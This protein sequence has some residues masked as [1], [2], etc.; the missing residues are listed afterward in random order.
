[1]QMKLVKDRRSGNILQVDSEE[2]WVIYVLYTED[3]VVIWV[4]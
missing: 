3:L 4:N 2:T 1:M